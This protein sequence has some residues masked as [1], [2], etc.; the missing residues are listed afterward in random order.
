MNINS[1][2]ELCDET[3]MYRVRTRTLRPAFSIFMFFARC[4]LD[5]SK[6][7]ILST[8][9]LGRNMCFFVIVLW[10]FE[11]IFLDFCD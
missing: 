2:V 3:H 9:R 5:L 11:E 7:L 10:H 1:H 6:A 8:I 4:T